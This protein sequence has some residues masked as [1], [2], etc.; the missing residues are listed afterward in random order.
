MPGRASSSPSMDWVSRPSLA[1][2][3]RFSSELMSDVTVE[4]GSDELLVITLS[5]TG[6]LRQVP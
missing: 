6:F 4:Y 3:N 2:F 5:H 1:R